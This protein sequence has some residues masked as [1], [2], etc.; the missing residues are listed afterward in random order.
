VGSQGLLIESL[1]GAAIYAVYQSV[2]A[3]NPASVIKV[4]TSFAALSE[5]GPG[6]K[7]ETSFFMD[8]ELN[9]KTRVL[10]GDLIL[11]ATGDPDGNRT[12][13]WRPA[14]GWTAVFRRLLQG[15]PRDQASGCRA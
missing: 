6:H 9:K 2:V 11:H 13:G 1:D 15:R 5:F 4:A 14:G 7:F 8:G 12:R 10:K 3:F